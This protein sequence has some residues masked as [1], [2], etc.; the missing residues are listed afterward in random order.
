MYQIQVLLRK[1]LKAAWRYRWPAVLVSW[2]VCAAGWVGVM[3][4]PDT[5]EASARLY[6]DADAILTPLLQGLTVNSSLASQ[7]DILQ[8]TLLSRPNL[9]KLISKTDLELQASNPGERQALIDRLLTEIRIVPQ[10]RNLFTFA[11]RNESAK[12]A[13]DVVQATLTSF[14]ESKAGSNRT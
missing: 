2:L 9:D 4:I 13:Y 8:R 10:A 7:V 5:Y 1:Q 14:I 11:H 6:I 3:R 12:L